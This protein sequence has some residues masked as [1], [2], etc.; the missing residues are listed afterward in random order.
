MSLEI[1]RFE[2]SRG[3]QVGLVALAVLGAAAT[4]VGAALAPD[5]LWASWLLSGYYTLG[6]ALSGLCLVAIHYTTGASWSVVVRRTAEAMAS[7]LPL[8]VLLLAAVFLMRPR[9]YSWAEWPGVAAADPAA[10]FKRAWLSRSFFLARAAVYAVLWAGFAAAIARRSRRQDIDSDR[11]WTHAN[12]RLSAAFLP[13]FGVT[14]TLASVDWIM[15]LEPDWYST[16]FAFYNFAGLLQSGLAALI[17]VTFWMEG[18]GPLRGVLNPE[19]RHDLGKLLFAL[20]SFW[21]YLWFSQYMLVWYANVPEE[22]AYFV[23]RTQGGWLPLLLADVLLNW[24]VP[25][26]ALLSREAKR[27]RSTL[28]AIAATVLVGRWLDLY[29]MIFPSVV[30]DS[31][32]LAFWEVGTTAG[33]LGCFVLMLVWILRQAPTIPIG[34]PQLDE[35]LRYEQ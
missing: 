30:G 21:M 13:V 22:T 6:L 9:L 28:A 24:V 15:S 35:S 26:V 17:L 1:G 10:A 11:R 31:P 25:F 14:F 34:D 3:Q 19:H 32:R 2:I 20:S 27:R 8:A 16:I 5:R 12:V 23:R 29:L 4:A 33:A 7:T 18:R